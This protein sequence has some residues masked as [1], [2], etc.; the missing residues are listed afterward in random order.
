MARLA[1]LPHAAALRTATSEAAAA[2]GLTNE[3][4][5]LR[6]GLSADLIVV[7]RSPGLT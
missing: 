6:V 7:R 5:A 2:L 3:T 1:D 4:G